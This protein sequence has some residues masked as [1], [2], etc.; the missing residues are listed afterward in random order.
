MSFPTLEDLKMSNKDNNIVE[1]I[2]DKV[3][4]S[5]YNLL[6]TVTEKYDEFWAN[7]QIV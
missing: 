7:F 3:L 4:E 6:K 2:E 1:E 5:G